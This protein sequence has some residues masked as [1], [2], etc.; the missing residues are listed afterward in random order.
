VYPHRASLAERY[1]FAQASNGLPWL[2]S[3]APSHLQLPIVI[4]IVV[5]MIGTVNRGDH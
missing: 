4:V 3:P 5:M 1:P 2:L